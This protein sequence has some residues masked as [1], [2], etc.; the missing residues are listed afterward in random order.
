MHDRA[1]K[2]Y[3]QDSLDALAKFCEEKRLALGQAK[4][5]VHDAFHAVT[6]WDFMEVPRIPGVPYVCVREATG[7]GKT[8]RIGLLP[9]GGSRRCEARPVLLGRSCPKSRARSKQGVRRREEKGA[10]VRFVPALARK[11]AEAVG[12]VRERLPML[13]INAINRNSLIRTRFV[14]QSICDD[15][16]VPG[17]STATGRRWRPLRRYTTQTTTEA[18]PI[19][20][21]TVVADASD[22]SDSAWTLPQFG[23]S[24]LVHPVREPADGSRVEV[25]DP[26]VVV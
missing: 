19:S 18:N 21:A 9:Q 15:I 14:A 12:G 13:L 24:H 7:R 20:P 3:Q 11:A 4:R 22:Q 8:I 16:F 26:A 6:G 2:E 10:A 5:P 1:L 17:A 25:A 23:V